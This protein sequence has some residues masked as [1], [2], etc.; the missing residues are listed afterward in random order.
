M[1]RRT[2]LL[3]A[4]ILTAALGTAL[5]WLYVQGADKRAQQTATL[6][7]ALF[8]SKELNAGAPVAGAVITRQVSP[9][10]AATAYTDQSQIQGLK[11]KKD[12]AAGQLLVKGMLDANAAGT[13][14][15]PSG[16]AV[17][18]SFNQ[19]NLV[20]ADLGV[21]DIV[22]VYAMTAGGKV[23]LRVKDIQ[24]RTIGIV[25]SGATPPTPGAANGGAKWPG[26]A[27]LSARGPANWMVLMSW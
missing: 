23:E 7:P 9:E 18:L 16:G 3:I 13:G 22:D 21:G 6:Q 8:L 11:L 20:P 4:S 2:L 26:M 19:P 25:A 1:A 14:R 10:V 27:K 5:I 24:V 12:A 15:F 17:A